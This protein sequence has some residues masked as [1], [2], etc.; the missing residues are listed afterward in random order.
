MTVERDLQ[1]AKHLAP[2]VWQGPA[3]KNETNNINN[4]VICC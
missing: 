1:G 3:S 4:V 2:L